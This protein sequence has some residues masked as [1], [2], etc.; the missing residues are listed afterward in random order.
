MDSGKPP[1]MPLLSS[2]AARRVAV[3]AWVLLGS[4]CYAEP[5][6]LPAIKIVK[7]PV[8]DGKVED[9]EWEGASRISGFVDRAVGRPVAE[10]MTVRLAYDSEAIYVGFI[11]FDSK[12]EAIVARERTPGADLDDDDNI[13]F[14]VNTFGLR[15]W[16][17]ISRFSIN[18]LGTQWENIAGG[19]AAKREWR[20]LWQ[21]AA[22]RLPNGWSGEMR[23]PWKILDYPSGSSRSMDLYITR[24]QKRTNIESNW[25]DVGAGEDPLRFAIWQGVEPPPKPPVSLEYLAYVAPEYDDPDLRARAGI[26]VRA[27]LGDRLTALASVSPDFRNIEQE[28]AG[29]NFVRT[30]RFFN[31]VRP[32]FTEGGDFFSLTQTFGAGTFFYSNRIRSFDFGAK[33]FGKPDPSLSVGLLGTYGGAGDIASVARVAKKL[34][35]RSDVS[36]FATHADFEGERSTLTGGT[37]YAASGTFGID[38]QYGRDETLD[39]T[40]EAWSLGVS[41]SSPNWFALWRRIKV[42]EE[43]NPILAL[44]PWPDRFGDYLYAEHWRDLRTGPIRSYGTDLYWTNFRTLEGLSQEQGVSTGLGVTF[45]N[46]LRLGANYSQNTYLGEDEQIWFLSLTVNSSNRFRRTRIAYSFGDRGGRDARFAE[47]GSSQRILGKVDIG[48]SLAEALNDGETNRQ[49]ILT[50]GYEID[51]T[52]SLTARIVQRDP[53]E[54]NGYLSYRL[55]GGVGTEIYVIIGD[56]NA[57]KFSNRVSVKLVRAF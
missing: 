38:G 17:Q 33:A 37:F 46:D 42:D 14:R 16:D 32:F 53:G 29:I 47:I 51:P 19:R 15:S 55:A 44:I 34:S 13:I 50:V 27:R 48:L 26:D 1:A 20:G 6:K 8:I 30:E 41:Y 54:L 9:A 7:P 31:E 35:P 4:V 28:I 57:E 39:S 12:P 36:L 21:S 18:P 23:I 24:T 52:R 45:R 40:E 2:A 49:G 10:D 25:P 3:L 56:P 5:L 43:F 11:A 22:M